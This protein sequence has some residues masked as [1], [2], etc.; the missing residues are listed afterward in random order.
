MTD[1]PRWRQLLPLWGLVALALFGL[2]WPLIRQP[3]F[4][5]FR[6]DWGIA[7]FDLDAARTLLLAAWQP[8]GLGGPTT[9][10]TDVLAR[11]ISSLVSLTPLPSAT[12]NSALVVGAVVGAALAMSAFLVRIVRLRP[13]P[14][15]LGALLYALSPLVYDRLL[16]GYLWYLLAYAL[17]PVYLWV[18]LA[19]LERPR[20]SWRHAAASAL[21]YVTLGMQIHF[22]IIAPVVFLLAATLLGQAR[23]AIPLALF[24][25]LTGLGANAFWFIPLVT[26]DGSLQAISSGATVTDWVSSRST[27]SWLQRLTLTNHPNQYAASVLSLNAGLAIGLLGSLALAWFGG[28]AAQPRRRWAVVGLATILFGLGVV[29]LLTPPFAPGVEWLFAHVTVV[30]MFRE[31][32]HWMGAVAFGVALAA[33]VSYQALLTDR[34]WVV[35]QLTIAGGAAL[36]GAASLPFWHGELRRELQPVVVNPAYERLHDQQRTVAGRAFWW[37]TIGPFRYPGSSAPINYD[38][39]IESF[40]Q[41]SLPTEGGRLL[42]G[43]RATQLR[44]YLIDRLVEGDLAIGGLL[45][46]V[47]IHDLFIREDVTSVYP[48]VTSVRDFP[49]SVERL[50]GHRIGDRLRA[51]PGI[52]L[53][54]GTPT[55]GHFALARPAELV[56]IAESPI[57]SGEDL[58]GLRRGNDAVFFLDPVVAELV[59]AGQLPV[60]DDPLSQREAALVSQAMTQVEPAAF[61]GE[62]YDARQGWTRALYWWWRDPFVAAAREQAVIAERD[63]TLAVPLPASGEPAALWVKAGALSPGTQLEVG[64]A[65][66]SALLAPKERQWEWLLALT[67]P[68]HDQPTTVQLRSRLGSPLVASLITTPIGTAVDHSSGSVVPLAVSASIEQLQALSPTDYRV[69]VDAHTPFWLL[70]RQSFHPG[71]V[72]TVQAVGQPAGS[73]EPVLVD[74]YANAFRIGET[75]QLTIRIQYRPQRL[76]TAGLVVSFMTLAL[77]AATILVAPRLPRQLSIGH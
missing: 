61:A 46:R 25:A 67:V 17:L 22:L 62:H 66:T 27:P 34:R 30:R 53:I 7:P 42:Y 72:A 68:A 51:V 59:Q 20:W 57:A 74:G 73:S 75:G 31:P 49:T 16:L 26:S 8:G 41:P 54:S 47:A 10:G 64:T 55:V 38:P 60:A 52:E 39:V 44:D 5:G 6:H 35:R 4:I 63:D 1:Q 19:F 76:H 2:L 69:V 70:L 3:G 23:R 13:V 11:L 29:S 65:A 48:D 40:A 15:A 18:S 28:L 12:W 21:I 71:W 45:K 43:G 50:S 56:T 37:P 77:L 9:F 32:V 58:G 33:A 36:I 24:H 14:A